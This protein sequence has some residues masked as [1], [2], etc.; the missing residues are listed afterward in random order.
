MSISTTD[1]SKIDHFLTDAKNDVRDIVFNFM[2]FLTA[3]ELRSTIGMFKENYG[4]FEESIKN[5][6]SELEKEEFWKGLKQHGLTGKELDRKLS[7]YYISREHYVA[8]R[9]S[10]VKSLLSLGD[11]LRKKYSQAKREL[12][13]IKDWPEKAQQKY[14]SV[15]EKFRKFRISKERL[16]DIINTLLKS[17]VDVIG[18]GGLASEFKDSTEVVTKKETTPSIQVTI[19]YFGDKLIEKMKEYYEH[20]MRA[21][22]R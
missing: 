2:E 21:Q 3:P 1:Y 19:Y 14:N 17:I 4:Y 9:N 16:F 18:I 20:Q 5:I 15:R 8:S 6:P 11:E 7:I 10:F 12:G 22:N 13:K